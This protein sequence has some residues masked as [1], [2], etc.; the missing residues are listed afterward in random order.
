MIAYYSGHYES[1]GLNC[2]ACVKADLQFLYFGVVLPGSTSDKI[3]YP[4][5]PGLKE[6]IDYLPLGL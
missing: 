1:D 3:S 6:T 4:L 5:A 2:Q